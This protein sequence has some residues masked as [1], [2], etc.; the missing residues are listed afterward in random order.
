MERLRI[1]DTGVIDGHWETLNIEVPKQNYYF[2]VPMIQS[3]EILFLRKNSESRQTGEVS[4]LN[5]SDLKTKIL[6]EGQ[7]NYFGN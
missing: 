3:N 5:L 2:A 6:I 4:V 7:N 1:S